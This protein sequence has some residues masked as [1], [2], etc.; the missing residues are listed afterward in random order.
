MP[1]YLSVSKQCYT[2]YLLQGFESNQQTDRQS[3]LYQC[4]SSNTHHFS[5]YFNKSRLR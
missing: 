4:Q 3:L 5:N 2:F 1:K